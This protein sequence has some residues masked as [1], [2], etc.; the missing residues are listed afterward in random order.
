MRPGKTGESIAKSAWIACR[1]PPGAGE[2]GRPNV[3]LRGP[4]RAPP[5]GPILI[6]GLDLMLII[7]LDFSKER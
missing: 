2:A 4:R 6:L 3:G 7:E 1:Q 5:V